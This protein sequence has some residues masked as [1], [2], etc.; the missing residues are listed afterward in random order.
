MKRNDA[1]QALRRNTYLVASEKS[2][3]WALL[4]RADYGDCKLQPFTV[5]NKAEELALWA[6]LS[7]AQLYRV[8]PH[9]DLHGWLRRETWRGRGK[10]SAY[11]LLPREPD[12]ACSCVRV[13][14]RDLSGPTKGLTTRQEVSH[15]ETEK[16]S[17][18]TTSPQVEQP[19]VLREAGTGEGV[20]KGCDRCSATPALVD[21]GGNRFCA[22]C[23][24]HL[25]KESA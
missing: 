17:P 1:E 15:H 6:G 8:F 23:A 5:P 7:R 19:F 2:V 21:N 13:A 9:L 22:T 4:S 16:V 24:P 14:P 20:S 3:M 11:E 10:K 12:E 18:S 25:F